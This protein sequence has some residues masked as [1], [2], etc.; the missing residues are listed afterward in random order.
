M[1]VQNWID[2]LLTIADALK[3]GEVAAFA[4]TYDEPFNDSESYPCFVI[5]SDS[6]TDE[7]QGD[8][9]YP[10][11]PFRRT[12]EVYILAKCT[13]NTKTA[14]KT[15]YQAVD[16]RATLLLN[17]LTTNYFKQELRVLSKSY[18]KFKIGATDV[19]ALHLRFS[20]LMYDEQTSI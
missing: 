3:I 12:T 16:A 2:A 15:A 8:S 10:T 20:V 14:R 19:Q 7:P 4:K 11:G 5:D 18:P 1:N 9:S 6:I 13:D 17:K